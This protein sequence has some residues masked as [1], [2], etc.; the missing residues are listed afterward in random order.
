[1]HN[2][3]LNRFS[4]LEVRKWFALFLMIF[5]VTFFSSDFSVVFAQNADNREQG[6]N[7]P[8]SRRGSALFAQQPSSKPNKKK[9]WTVERSLA[10]LKRSTG[11]EFDTIPEEQ[12]DRLVALITI[13]G[14]EGSGNWTKLLEADKQPVI[15]GGRTSVQIMLGIIANNQKAEECYVTGEAI[16][17]FTTKEAGSRVLMVDGKLENSTY[18]GRG[19]DNGDGTASVTDKYNRTWKGAILPRQ[20]GMDA[21][22]VDA[23]L[24]K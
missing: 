17:L 20:K 22:F 15:E 3:V 19:I 18:V 10:A 7:G 1:M 2:L 13:L 4:T 5:A 24:V 21:L 6:S 14:N 9:F 11:D 23:K 12:T 16:L 8:Q